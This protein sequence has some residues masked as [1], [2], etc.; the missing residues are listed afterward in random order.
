MRKDIRIK[1]ALTVGFGLMMMGTAP[2][3][4]QDYTSVSV[5]QITVTNVT[6]TNGSYAAQ[7][8]SQGARIYHHYGEN[9]CPAGLQPVTIS[10]V[11]CCGQP[12]QGISYQ[13]AMMT[14]APRHKVKRYKPQ[15]NCAVGTKGCTYD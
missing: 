8:S 11:I 15:S 13:Q 2:T 5:T 9:F 4:A 6:V 3:L 12:N 10:G 7:A 1:T 14:S